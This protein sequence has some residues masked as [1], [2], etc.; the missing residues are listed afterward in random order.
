MVGLDHS[1]PAFLSIP[2]GPRLPQLSSP[3]AD[4]EPSDTYDLRNYKPSKR[5]GYCG[6]PYLHR[7]LGYSRPAGNCDPGDYKPSLRFQTA[8]R[9]V[10][11]TSVRVALDTTR[12]PECL[13]IASRYALGT[14]GRAAPDTTRLL[15]FAGHCGAALDTTRQL[16]FSSRVRA[17]FDP[18][19]IAGFG[20]L[21]SQKEQA[22]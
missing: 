7:S 21:G 8:S 2:T 1:G 13:S 19:G 11:G 20:Q 9:R 4:A 6:S 12:R 16:D 3:N 5:S 18:P 14:S 15:G 22:A 10:P 17:A